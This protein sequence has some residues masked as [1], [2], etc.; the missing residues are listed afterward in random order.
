MQSPSNIRE[1]GIFE[2]LN[3]KQ[4]SKRYILHRLYYISLRSIRSLCLS[5]EN[6]LS[7]ASLTNSLTLFCS[8][9]ISRFFYDKIKDCKRGSFCVEEFIIVC[10]ELIREVTYETK[11]L[12]LR[13]SIVTTA[14]VSYSGFQLKNGSLRFVTA[15][16]FRLRK[17]GCLELLLFLHS[18]QLLTQKSLGF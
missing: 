8:N 15:A 14:F 3:L 13:F 6:V 17:K 1:P 2:N 16:Y 18:S 11:L 10:V 7:H 9:R 12:R 5:L 4:Y